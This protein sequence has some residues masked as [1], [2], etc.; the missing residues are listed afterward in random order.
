M[1]CICHWYT[2][3]LSTSKPVQNVRH[4]FVHQLSQMVCAFSFYGFENVCKSEVSFYNI[5]N[6]ICHVYYVLGRGGY[7]FGSVGLS[8]CLLG[9]MG[10]MICLSKGGLRSLSASSLYFLWLSS[11]VIETNWKRIPRL[12]WFYKQLLGYFFVRN[13]NKP[14]AAGQI[15]GLNCPERLGPT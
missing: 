8:V 4:V 15:V 12:M 3:T 11:Q 9:N 7:V 2:F 13:T 6:R 5:W 10:V 14:L 1:T